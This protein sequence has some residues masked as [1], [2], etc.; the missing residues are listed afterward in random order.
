MLTALGFFHFRE[1]AEG[2]SR[3]PGPIR[4]LHRFSNTMRPDFGRERQTLRAVVLKFDCGNV[5][6]P[7]PRHITVTP[8]VTEVFDA[9]RDL[10]AEIAEL[11]GGYPKGNPSTPQAGPE[12]SPLHGTRRE[13]RPH[14]K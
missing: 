1:K 14:Q 4:P 5:Y 6:V 10:L 3:V 13:G 9:A 7:Y 8:T 12:M 2:E 11:N